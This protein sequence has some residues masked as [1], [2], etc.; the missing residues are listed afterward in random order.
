M[1]RC[2]VAASRRPCSLLAIQC[3][4]S[5]A[6]ASQHLG[7]G[8]PS[9]CFPNISAD[10]RA[11]QVAVECAMLRR[12]RARL[13]LLGL[14]RR[15]DV[16]L[17]MLRRRDHSSECFVVARRLTRHGFGLPLDKARVGTSSICGAAPPRT[18]LAPQLRLRTSRAL[19]PRWK[20]AIRDRVPE[21]RVRLARRR[22]PRSVVG[23]WRAARLLRCAS[24]CVL[25]ALDGASFRPCDGRQTMP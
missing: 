8:R 7:A 6:G 22:G 14:G 23:E 3:E 10:R 16:G 19:A 13:S 9:W 15:R 5:A 4:C 11:F 17:A 25:R 24:S 1:R 21:S 12:A 18:I 2:D 20:R